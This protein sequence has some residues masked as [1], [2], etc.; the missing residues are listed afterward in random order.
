MKEKEC[1]TGFTLS[2]SSVSIFLH[3]DHFLSL[4]VIL[5]TKNAWKLACLV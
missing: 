5:S 4:A 3:H 2:I 1:F